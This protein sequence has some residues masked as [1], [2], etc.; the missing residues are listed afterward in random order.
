M[1]YDLDNSLYIERLKMGDSK[2]RH[3]FW[4]CDLFLQMAS[5]R[6]NHLKVVCCSLSI[7]AQTI[8]LARFLNLPREGKISNSR[9][10]TPITMG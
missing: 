9:L 6:C 7:R 5:S 3:Q 4:Q 10:R 1:L 2:Q 8:Q